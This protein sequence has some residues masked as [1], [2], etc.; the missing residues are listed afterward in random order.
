MNR[1]KNK[2]L[3]NVGIPKF[4]GTETFT[5]AQVSPRRKHVTVLFTKT[6][7]KKEKKAIRNKEE[8]NG[9]EF[10]NKHQQFGGGGE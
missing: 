6:E 9:S 1:R 3:K 8:D 7:E 5:K 10:S 2:Y 4:K